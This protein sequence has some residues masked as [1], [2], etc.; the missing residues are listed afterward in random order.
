MND[1]AQ[2]ASSS[3][4]R[5]IGELSR[6]LRRSSPRCTVGE[7][8]LRGQLN[9]LIWEIGRRSFEDGFRAAHEQC[10]KAVEDSGEFPTTIS[11]A[12]RPRLAP[13]AEGQVSLRS[14]VQKIRFLMLPAFA[15]EISFWDRFKFRGN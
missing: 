15:R 8:G 12:G 6:F 2:G 1:Y 9:G 5:T 11:Y 10:A 13:A 4:N 14:S 7:A 3:L